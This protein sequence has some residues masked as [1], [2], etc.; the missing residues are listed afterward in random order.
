MD[1]MN[2]SPFPVVHLPICFQLFITLGLQH[3]RLPCSHQLLTPTPKKYSFMFLQTLSPQMSMVIR[4]WFLRFKHLL[5]NCFQPTSFYSSTSSTHLTSTS[6]AKT[7]CLPCKWLL[8]IFFFLWTRRQLFTIE[9]LV[10][11]TLALFSEA[12]SQLVLISWLFW[13]LECP[14][15][16][17]LPGFLG[18]SDGKESVSNAGDQ[19]SIPGLG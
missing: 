10:F 17:F 4:L 14:F 16:C 12:S 19:N 13:F 2:S 18:G 3:A 7:T 9:L 6:Q 15:F 1:Q 8:I 11:W 5:H